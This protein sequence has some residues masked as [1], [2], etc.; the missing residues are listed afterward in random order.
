[1]N[2]RSFI[3]SSASGIF[4]AGVLSQI[5]SALFASKYS[6]SVNI[7]IGFQSFVLREEINAKPLETLTNMSKLGYSHVEMCSPAG[8]APWNFPALTKYSGTELKQLINDAG[9]AC[10]SSH[11]TWDELVKNLDERIDFAHQMGLKHMV[12]SGG[13]NGKTIDELKKQCATLNA[14]GEKITRAGMVAGYHNHNG[15]FEQTKNGRP[16]YDIIL[17]ELDPSK[18]K[19][20]F[21]V[22]AIQVG[23]KAQ[24][25]FRKHPGRFISAHLQDYSRDNKNKQVV[26]GQNGMVN[27]KDF[28]DAGKVGGLQWVYVEMESDP[29]TLEGSVKYLKNL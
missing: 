16:D 18:V 9:L 10:Y 20:Q 8:Y 27:W 28:F 1:M 14:I 26:L 15:E 4:A 13:L 5:P 19:M 23:Y 12:C 6:K 21:Q 17:E 7:P 25:Y 22:A 3:G 11:F 24:D 29:G 2:R